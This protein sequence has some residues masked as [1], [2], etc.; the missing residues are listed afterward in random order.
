LG[1]DTT[2][3]S[4]VDTLVTTRV[5]TLAV[6][7]TIVVT[8]VDTVVSVDTVVVGD[9]VLVQTRL[10]AAAGSEPL[11]SG[12]TIDSGATATLS[13]SA[14][15]PLDIPTI[16]TSV[17]WLSD[18]PGTA[19]VKGTTST[20][21]VQA[22]RPGTANIFAI[23]S[24]LAATVPTTVRR[25]E[26]SSPPPPLPQGSQ[27]RFFRAHEPA[28]MTKISER[29]FSA[30]QEGWS[31]EFEPPPEIIESDANAPHS[32]PGVMRFMYREGHVSG[33][34]GGNRGTES[35]LPRE[36][37]YIYMTW[38][39]S[40]NWQGHSTSGNKQFYL[41]TANPDGAGW[42]SFFAIRGID[43]GPLR[44]TFWE[45]DWRDG[46]NPLHQSNVGDGT[47]NRGQWYEL[48]FLITANTPGIR[49]GRLEIWKNGLKVMDVR[50]FGP[51]HE[52]E[53]PGLRAFSWV[54]IWGG[55]G[56]TVEEDMYIWLDHVY[57]SG[58]SP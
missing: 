43:D 5:D 23:A 47:L 57:L 3:V 7:D 1:T 8:V 19:S 36:V 16:P 28:G 39:V 25:I 11:S 30:I 6:V 37:L 14:Q 13:V 26:I 52:G 46:S 27:S 53:G 51:V 32:P 12:L 44:I 17:V 34:S 10:V 45:Q 55:Q 40:T 18:A 31:A 15:N 21:T 9:T 50:N 4:R 42:H 56:D 33:G 29:P 35:F 24:G 54:P 58:K 41:G 22:V 48:E 20:A 49:N 2:F 38:K